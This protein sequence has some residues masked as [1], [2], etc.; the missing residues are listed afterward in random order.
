MSVATL[1]G[2]LFTAA[3]PALL[4]G[5]LIIKAQRANNCYL[6]ANMANR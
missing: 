5:F 1:N 2:Y 3:K 4:A 6:C